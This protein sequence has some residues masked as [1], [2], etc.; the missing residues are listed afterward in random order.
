MWDHIEWREWDKIKIGILFVQALWL[1]ILE[2]LG[3]L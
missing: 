2:P 3:Q 1:N